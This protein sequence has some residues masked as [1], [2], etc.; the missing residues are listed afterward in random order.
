[1][2]VLSTFAVL[3]M[4]TLITIYLT[5]TYNYGVL[6]ST[7]QSFK[8]FHF[9]FLYNYRYLLSCT[10]NMYLG[11]LYVRSVCVAYFIRYIFIVYSGKEVYAKRLNI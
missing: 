1:M 9:H 10:A 4:M 11:V 7:Q 8:I 5:W 3:L 2:F 6:Q